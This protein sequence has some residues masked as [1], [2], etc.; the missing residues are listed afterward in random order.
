MLETLL[1]SQSKRQ[2]SAAGTI[3]SVAAHTALIAAALYATAQA[4]VEPTRI[5]ET[6]RPLYFPRPQSPIPTASPTTTRQTRS[7]GRR[8]IFVEPHL[9]INVPPVDITGIVSKPDDFGPTS[10][11]ATA[12]NV[13]GES[14]A[15]PVGS[16]FRADQ[17][18][19]RVAVVPG[20]PPPRYP[21]VL[22]SSGVEGQVIA[23]FVVDQQ[24]RAEEASLRFVRSDNQLFEGAV[25]VALRRMR[26]IP[27][28]VGGRKVRQLVQ[29]PF[30]FTLA[31]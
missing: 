1:E 9:D 11:L 23:V 20:A 12:P 21:E 30:V 2:G 5:P 7:V 25:R 17:V 27:A 26:F 22:R 28:E 4:R 24:G 14:G 15:S 16:P 10:I 31:R 8:L 18:D 3:M 29:M 19:K 13:G 6:V